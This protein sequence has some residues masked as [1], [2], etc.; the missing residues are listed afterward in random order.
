MR[1]SAHAQNHKSCKY[2]PKS[3]TM[4]VNNVRNFAWSDWYFGD[5]RLLA[6]LSLR[7]RIS[8]YLAVPR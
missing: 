4:I 2:V 3:T 7:M 1:L 8:V 5:Q 6:T